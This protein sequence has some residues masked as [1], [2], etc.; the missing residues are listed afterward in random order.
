MEW[1]DETDRY[2]PGG[3]RYAPTPK[4]VTVPLEL[5]A[6]LWRYGILAPVEGVLYGRSHRDRLAEADRL[7]AQ[8][9]QDLQKS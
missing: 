4:T 2:L 6:D 5:L 9:Y 1:T 3:D 8:A 7:M